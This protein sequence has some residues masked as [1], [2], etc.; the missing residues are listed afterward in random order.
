M[1]PTLLRSAARWQRRMHRGFT[2]IEMLVVFTLLALL[3]SIAV[4]RYLSTTAGARDK[5][6]LQNMATLRDALDKFKADQGHYPT[7][8]AELVQKQYLR[9]LPLDPVTESSAWTPLP[10][11][12]GLEAGVYDVGP[13]LLAASSPVSPTPATPSSAGQATP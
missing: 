4:P 10:Q 6:R 2:L 11:P 3:L 5:V 9:N 1:H 13:P 12:A 7:E 8:L